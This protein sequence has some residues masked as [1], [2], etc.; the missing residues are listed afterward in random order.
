MKLKKFHHFLLIALAV[1][2]LDQLTKWMS[3]EWLRYQGPKY[4]IGEWF[5]FQYQTNPG[6]AFGLEI[7]QWWGKI[8]LT[9]FRLGAMIA[10]IWYMRKLLSKNAH[11]GL[12]ICVS[13]ILA[14]AV[15][16][17][18]DSTFYGFLDPD[19]LVKDA[20]FT[21]FH[22]KVIDFIYIDMGTHWGYQFWPIFNIA[23][24][25]IFIAVAIIL[26][27]QKAF[28][29]SLKNE[30]SQQTTEELDKE[31]SPEQNHD[32]SISKIE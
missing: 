12:I 29:N 18:I 22:G 30:P 6:M 27:R 14:G 7:G 5:K 8:V 17:L 13:L 10:I 24:S 16:N 28:F 15:G 31:E 1:I 32:A 9:L 19:L 20:P 25:S 3:Y 11:K 26:V 23:D 4:L 21:L 2:I